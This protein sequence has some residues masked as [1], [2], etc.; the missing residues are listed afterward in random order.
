MATESWPLRAENGK[1]TIKMGKNRTFSKKNRIILREKWH[2]CLVIFY[3]FCLS[4]YGVW[5]FF[6]VFSKLNYIWPFESPKM[7][8]AKKT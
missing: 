5:I 4:L 8:K 2:N 7:T 1:K 6:A 3:K